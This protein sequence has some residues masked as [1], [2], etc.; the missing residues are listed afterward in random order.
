MWI[1]VND[2]Y[3]ARF[4]GLRRLYGVQ[5][6]KGGILEYWELLEA[7]HDLD[8]L[9]MSLQT[10]DS[11][12][13]GWTRVSPP[14]PANAAFGVTQQRKSDG[15]PGSCKRPFEPCTWG[16]CKNK[17]THS[18]DRCFTKHPGLRGAKSV[19][20]VDPF[21]QHLALPAQLS[22]RQ[23]ASLQAQIDSFI[24]QK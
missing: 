14:L 1:I 24:D 2:I 17:L 19:P 13:P 21:P 6:L 18:E 12:H 23:R 7:Y 3:L 22:S 16:P 5:K 20:K 8:R 11:R 15:T 4:D 10:T 9:N